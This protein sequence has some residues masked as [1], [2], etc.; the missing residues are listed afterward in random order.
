MHGRF[1]ARSLSTLSAP[2][3]IEHIVE[4]EAMLAG[5]NRVLRPRGGLLLTVPQHRWLWSDVDTRSHHVRRY[6]ARESRDK[7]ERAWSRRK[8]QTF[9][10]L[11][12]RAGLKPGDRDG[13]E[14]LDC[15]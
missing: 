10:D 14:K 2:Y 15:G 7:V 4:D 11:R 6:T 8:S 13:S 1:R 3:V 12:P 9:E 5:I